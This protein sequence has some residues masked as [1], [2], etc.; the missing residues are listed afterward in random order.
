MTGLSARGVECYSA[1]HFHFPSSWLF[2]K[3]SS[4]RLPIVWGVPCGHNTVLSSSTISFFAACRVRRVTQDISSFPNSS[5]ETTRSMDRCQETFT[6]LRSLKSKETPRHFTGKFQQRTCVFRTGTF[7]AVTS[8]FSHRNQTNKALCSGRSTENTTYMFPSFAARGVDVARS[9]LWS[10]LL[11]V[12]TSTSSRESSVMTSVGKSSA[13]II[14]RSRLESSS[15]IK[16]NQ[17]ITRP[18]PNLGKTKGGGESN[19]RQSNYE[20]EK[21]NDETHGQMTRTV[22]KS[23]WTRLYRQTRARM[24]PQVIRA[25]DDAWTD[26]RTKTN[27]HAI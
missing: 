22:R 12:E 9:P 26:L 18:G 27:A 4:P 13:R 15:S 14:P 10:S 7:S 1:D 11:S 5:D 6:I 19:K 24:W 25:R 20:Q 2:H 8:Q 23:T 3:K 16:P 21:D 17:Y